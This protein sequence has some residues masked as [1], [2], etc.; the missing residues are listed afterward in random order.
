MHNANESKK[1][2]PGNGCLWIVAIIAILGIIWIVG[3][4]YSK[5]Q[6]T[7][8]EKAHV[9]QKK[10]KGEAIQQVERYLKEHLKDPKSYEGIDWYT[11]KN[12]GQSSLTI[13]H[14]YRAKNSFGGYVVEC[15]AFILD[16]YNNI[17]DV[18]DYPQSKIK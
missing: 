3:D 4:T 12:E 7:P 6:L 13:I 16:D 11:L 15:K 17:I 10:K 2:P 8:E 14:K 18:Y 5:N 1:T 9:A